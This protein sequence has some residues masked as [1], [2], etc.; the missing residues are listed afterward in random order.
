MAAV[1]YT[2]T[3]LADNVTINCQRVRT[4]PSTL[5]W[6]VRLQCQVVAVNG[7]MLKSVDVDVATLV[8]GPALTTFK[9]SL[10]AALGALATSRGISPN[11]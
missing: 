2:E 6:N 5:D 8:S 7:D 1:T 4:G 10:T 11:L 9:N 3:T